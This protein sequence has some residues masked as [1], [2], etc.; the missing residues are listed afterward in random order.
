MIKVLSWLLGCIAA[1]VAGFMRCLLFVKSPWSVEGVFYK[2][3][4]LTLVR[5][6]IK[7]TSTLG[8]ERAIV[9]LLL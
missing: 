2:L 7:E 5:Q 4:T 6:N 1:R 8:I 9:Y 3:Y